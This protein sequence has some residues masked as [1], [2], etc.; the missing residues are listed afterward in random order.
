MIHTWPPGAK[1]FEGLLDYDAR[2]LERA[3]RVGCPHCGE[4]LDRADF[5]RK[6]RGLPPAWEEG[7]SRR[8]SLCCSREGCRKRLTPPSARF[9]G[10][11]VYAAVV[12]L[13]ASLSALVASAVPARTLRRW[14]TWWA[15]PF[16]ESAFF[17]TARA[18]L[19]PPVDVTRLPGSLVERFLAAEPSTDLG[20]LN[21]LLFVSPL[22]V[23][24]PSFS[25][26]GP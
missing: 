4:R 17:R 26:D 12:M 1:F 13:V 9:L 6:P 8:F 7:F 5:P 10:R 20:L 11:R 24:A 23:S 14:S 3:Q 2:E 18:R 21:A 25:R 16:V 19:M 22:S 15:G